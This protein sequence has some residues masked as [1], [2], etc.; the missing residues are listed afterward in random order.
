MPRFT[1]EK[2]TRALNVLADAIGN[3]WCKLATKP[4]AGDE[5][6]NLEKH[7]QSC[8]IEMNKLAKQLKDLN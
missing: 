4:L 8:L 7:L 6:A 5:R 3:T 2:A 1:E